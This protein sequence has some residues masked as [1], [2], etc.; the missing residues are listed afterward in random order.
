MA[1]NDKD[2]I[3]VDIDD[4][5][6]GIIDKLSTSEGK[7]VAL[8]LPKRAATF[9]S[10]VNMK[11]LKRAADGANKN[12]ALITNEAGLL[13]LAGAAGIHVA[14]TLTSKPE[15]PLGPANLDDQE[16]TIQEDAGS[17]E[18]PLD[19]DKT[20]GQLAGTSGPPAADGVET[21]LLDN[22]D[23]PPEVA[24]SVKP[25]A[26]TF[27]PP[28]KKGKAG[29]KNKKLHIPNFDRFRLMLIIAGGILLLIIAIL[30]YI[31][32]SLPKATINIKTDA[33]NVDT[34]LDLSLS[35][36]VKTLDPATNTIPAKLASQ[37]K[38]YSQQVPTTGQ[39]NNGNKASGSVVMTAKS[40]AP[41][42][43]DTPPSV[44][45]GTGI[46]SNGQ[47]YITQQV[48]T[49]SSSSNSGNS[50][51]NYYQ[52]TSSTTVIAQNG[53]SSYNGA[54]TF[55]YSG[56]PDIVS[57]NVSSAISGGTDSIVQ[58]VNQNDINNAKA[59]IGTD[60]SIKGALQSQLKGEN[61]Y[62]IVATYVASAPVV[63]SSA[64]VGDQASNVTVT[65][66]ITYNMFGVKKDD[67]NT[68]IKN[69]VNTQIDTSKQSVLDTG[70]S[71]AVFNVNTISNSAAQLSMSTKA[72]AGPH[73]DINIIKQAAAGKKAGA[74]KSDIGNNPDVTGVDVKFSPFW[75]S[76][77]PKKTERITVNIAKP[78]TTKASNTSGNSP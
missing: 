55:T 36:G 25:G 20:V 30:L 45:T 63:T 64:N 47:T 74:I 49:F 54:T 76:T 35:T 69:S 12:L 7:V 14:K 8:V 13:P 11:L 58:I 3:Y 26:K 73:L 39:K 15:I 41:N 51:C 18:P 9:Q 78:T 60:N 43:H 16:E 23:L 37:Q 10:I 65:E 57:I 22:E 28:S 27:E 72:T 62:P 38:T 75:I 70:L 29:K 6:T 19:T 17:A 67:I 5:I 66:V 68:L 46:S 21:L 32:F 56:R 77:A 24:D 4:E 1:A 44:A 61:E 34:N 53:G 40:C 2:T 71:K 31:T 59:K 33:T 50:N 52:A 48:T 42:L